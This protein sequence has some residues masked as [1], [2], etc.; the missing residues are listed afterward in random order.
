MLRCSD[1]DLLMRSINRRKIE[2]RSIVFLEASAQIKTECLWEICGCV[3]TGIKSAT[4]NIRDSSQP[5]CQKWYVDKV[6]TFVYHQEINSK[7]KYSSVSIVS[8]KLFERPP[9]VMCK[10]IAVLSSVSVRRRYL[11]LRY[12]YYHYSTTTYLFIHFSISY[13][14]LETVWSSSNQG[15]Q[16]RSYN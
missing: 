4:S 6:G 2:T 13:S 9:N 12:V 3:A 14:I 11:K 1:L 16:R 15:K 5:K 10:A 7:C 8:V